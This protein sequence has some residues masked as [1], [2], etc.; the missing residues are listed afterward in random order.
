MLLFDPDLVQDPY[1]FYKTWREEQPLFKD[2]DTGDWIFSRHADILAALK[3]HEL[4]SSSAFADSEQTAIAL[5]LLSDDPPRHTKLRALVSR[6]FTSRTLKDIES[7]VRELSHSLAAQLN[8]SAAIDIAEEFTIEL[9]VAVIAQMMGI[10][11]E[12]GDDFKKWSDALVGTSEAVDMAER[13]P[14]IMAMAE[15][16]GS[17][18]PDRRANPGTDLISTV[19]NAEVDGERLS[20]EDIVGF[21]ILLLIAGNETTTNLLSNLL[22]HAASNQ[23]VWEA[24]RADRSKIDNAIEE[25][26]RFDAPVQ[27]VIRT[28]TKDIEM[29]GKQLAA[30]DTAVLFLGSANRDAQHHEAPDEFLLDRSQNSHMTFGHGIHFCIGAPLGRLEARLALEALLDRFSTVRHVHRENERTHSPMLRGFHHLWLEFDE[31]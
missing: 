22:H 21:C 15:F 8:A 12:R 17:L 14:D 1:P 2:K 26:L 23:G 29:H 3:D 24:L 11:V 31:A 9:P 25:I 16:F 6:A 19:V 13:M 27:F 5:P 18:I 7:G 4:F 10:P 20:D 30:G 28:I